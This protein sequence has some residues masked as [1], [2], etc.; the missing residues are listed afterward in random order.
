MATIT[1]NLITLV[2]GGQAYGGWKSLEVERGIPVLLHTGSCALSA[3]SQSLLRQYPGV[4]ITGED[5]AMPE[6]GAYHLREPV[7]PARL[8]ALLRSLH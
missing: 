6:L 3:E 2:V 5:C 7:K 4:V 1:E 8:R